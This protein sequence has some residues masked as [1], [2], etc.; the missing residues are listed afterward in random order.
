M[1]VDGV[2]DHIGNVVKIKISDS[3][4]DDEAETYSVLSDDF[5][6]VGGF[7]FQN[8]LDDT[9]YVHNIDDATTPTPVTIEWISTGIGT[10]QVKL[11]YYNGVD[12]WTTIKSDALGNG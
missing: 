1:G 6:I 11:E 5:S 9:G 3:D 8:P 4:Y 7:T 12:T 10:T 2:G